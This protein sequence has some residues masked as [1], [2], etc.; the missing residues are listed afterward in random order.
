MS[1]WTSVGCRLSIRRACIG[2]VSL[3]G[4]SVLAVAL[5]G[6]CPGSTGADDAALVRAVAGDSTAVPTSHEVGSGDEEIELGG[7]PESWPNVLFSVD[8]T[9]GPRDLLVRAYAYTIDGAPLPDGLYHWSFDN[10]IDE[11][12]MATHADVR[13][14]FSTGGVHVIRLT[15]TLLG[16]TVPVGC[17]AP[18][19][20]VEHSATVTVQPTISGTIADSAGQLVPGAAVAAEGV[21]LVAVAD[22]Q[23]RFKLP[24]PAGWSGN[25]APS[26]AGY[27]FKPPTRSFGATNG[28]IGGQDFVATAAEGSS[29]TDRMMGDMNCDGQ[30]DSGD[31][32][33]FVLALSNPAQYAAAFPGCPILNGDINGDGQTN[34]DDVNAFVGLMQ[35]L[36][37]PQPQDQAVQTSEDTPVDIVLSATDPYRLALQ[38]LIVSLPVSGTLMDPANQTVITAAQLPYTLASDGHIVTYRPNA[39]YSGSD[40]FTFRVNNGLQDSGFATVSITVVAVNDPPAAYGQSVSADED[41]TKVITLSGSDPDGDPLAYAIVSLPAHGTLKDGAT[42]QVIAA[43]QLPYTLASGGR[44]VKY[45]NNLAY[46]CGADSFTFQVNDGQANSAAATV[47]VTVVYGNHPPTADPQDVAVQAG[48]PKAITLTATD[49]HNDALTFSVE[50]PPVHGTLGGTAPNVT[51]TPTPGYSGSDSFA[52]CASDGCGESAPRAP[53]SSWAAAAGG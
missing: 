28:D 32:N 42:N 16:C 20:G 9:G 39:Q 26:A 36:V 50:V 48:V 44:Q 52:F 34:L 12:G 6:G 19:G 4:A 27:T 17:V 45:T 49:P 7:C 35:G 10:E 13:H 1:N 30:L 25:I 5:C 23:G 3:V 51:Y 43:S 2:W 14:T 46:V 18:S 11:G 53:A 38:Y 41:I 33:P 15:I 31:V 21:A 8:P 22:G 37:P 47:G 29:G 40:V 24:V